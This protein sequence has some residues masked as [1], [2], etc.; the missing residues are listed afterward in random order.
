[1]EPII[2]HISLPSV[3]VFSIYNC[4]KIG[5]PIKCVRLVLTSVLTCVVHYGIF[6]RRMKNGKIGHGSS[7]FNYHS[8]RWF[9]WNGIAI[10]NGARETMTRNKYERR[11]MIPFHVRK[12]TNVNLFRLYSKCLIR[13]S[14]TVQRR[15]I[16]IYCC[17]QLTVAMRCTSAFLF[18]IRVQRKSDNEMNYWTNYAYA[19]HFIFIRMKIC[20]ESTS[21]ATE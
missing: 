19:G 1:M 20:L 12:F 3:G 18:A 11:V 8:L 7:S 16:E 14:A 2:T 15:I 4:W 9:I 13:T 17:F 6:C 21:T 5:Q 10:C